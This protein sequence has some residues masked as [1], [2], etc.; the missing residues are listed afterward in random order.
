M[1][2]INLISFFCYTL[3]LLSIVGAIAMR[4]GAIGS[5]FC[6]LLAGFWYQIG[7]SFWKRE[8][9]AWWVALVSVI[10]FLIG[11][12]VSVYS[13]L[14]IPLF[15]QDVASVG[16]G[17]WISLFFTVLLS[18]LMIILLQSATRSEFRKKT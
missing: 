3:A 7:T 2:K 12:F 17:R 13:S 18:Y 10:L 1:K 9:W 4:S 16:Y 8:A 11:S 15:S 14:L 6:I 5:I